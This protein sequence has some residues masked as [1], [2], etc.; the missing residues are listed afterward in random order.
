M[1]LSIKGLSVVVVWH[2]DRA[3]TALTHNKWA[4][5]EENAGGLAD[6]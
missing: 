3:M 4:S 6:V 5:I 1:D 2:K